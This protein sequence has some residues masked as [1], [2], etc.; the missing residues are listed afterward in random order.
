[1]HIARRKHVLHDGMV[2]HAREF[3]RVLERPLRGTHLAPRATIV[4]HEL[5]V[6]PIWFRN[7]WA[8][9]G[10]GGGRRTRR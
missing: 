6:F 8:R 10:K 4:Q 9:F 2:L 1:M 3:R 5:S 7:E